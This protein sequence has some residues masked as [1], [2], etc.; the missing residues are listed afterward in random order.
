[1]YQNSLSIN[2]AM[3]TKNTIST[4]YSMGDY[5]AR[6]RVMMKLSTVQIVTMKSTVSMRV[7]TVSTGELSGNT[8]G[9]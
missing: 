7:F 3:I 8:I 1:M 5:L 9:W 2:Q 6:I 4:K